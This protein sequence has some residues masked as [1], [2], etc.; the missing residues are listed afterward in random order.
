MKNKRLVIILCV[1]AF[2]TVLIA[3]N[4]TLFTLQGISMNW[5]TTKYMLQDVKDYEI[6]EDIELGGSVFLLNKDEITQQLEKSNPYLRV[7]SLET[8]FPNKLVIH[9]AERESLYAIKITSSQYVILD[10]MG[11]VLTIT[12]DARMFEGNGANL[13]AVPIVIDFASLSL[14]REDFVEGEKVN[15]QYVANI[16]SSLSYSLREASYI[17]TTSKGVIKSI[18]VVSMGN[19]SKISMMTRSGIEINIVDVEN[20]TTKKLLLGFER[21]NHYHNLGSVNCVIDVWYCQETESI[22]ASVDEGI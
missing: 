2:L 14:K 7:V 19:S 15:S 20:L 11:K 9:C 10:E 4:S 21:Y 18:E 12:E 6:I 22:I 1:L 17:P 5:L 8:K 16:L 3:I 13:G